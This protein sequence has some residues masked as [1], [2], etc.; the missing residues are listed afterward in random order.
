MSN[1]QNSDDGVVE[2]VSVNGVIIDLSTV[3]HNLRTR[4]HSAARAAGKGDK[5][6]QQ[7][8][9]IGEA[10]LAEQTPALATKAFADARKRG[11]VSGRAAL[12]KLMG[13]P[14]SK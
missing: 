13:L 7:M 14:Q 5:A 1:N 2:C 10:I 3:S 12:E 11:R 8:K 9:E 6:R 4:F